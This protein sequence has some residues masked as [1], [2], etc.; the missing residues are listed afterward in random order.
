MRPKAEWEVWEN[1]VRLFVVVVVVV[2]CQQKS[3][4]FGLLPAIESAKKG[5]FQDDRRARLNLLSFCNGV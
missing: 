2:A 1:L 5:G 4:I 3:T